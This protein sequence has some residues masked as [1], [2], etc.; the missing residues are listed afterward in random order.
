MEP[1]E[2]CARQECQRD[3]EEARITEATSRFAREIA[4]H[5]A[6]ERRDQNEPEVG[7]V[8]LPVGIRLRPGKQQRQPSQRESEWKEPAGHGLRPP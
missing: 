7:R 1:E 8:M 5:D 3:E 4:E 6:D 2:A